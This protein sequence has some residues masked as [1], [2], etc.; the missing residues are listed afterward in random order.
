LIASIVVSGY[1]SSTL[2]KPKVKRSGK[3]PRVRAMH[4][5]LHP[6]CEACGSKADLEVHHIVPYH[7]NPALELE[8]ANLI[9][10]CEGPGVGHHLFWGHN[11]SYRLFN[12][13]VRADCEKARANAAHRA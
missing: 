5:R 1:H 7:I 6:C 4:L 11:G 9:T 13:H 8:P 2:A 12:P 10:L 3:W